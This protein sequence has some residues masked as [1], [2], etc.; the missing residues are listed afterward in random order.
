MS[1]NFFAGMMRGLGAAVG[2]TAVVALLIWILA[3]AVNLPWVGGYFKDAQGEVL[4]LIEEARLTDNFNRIES[5]LWQIEKN[6]AETAMAVHRLQ[7]QVLLPNEPR[8]RLYHQS[9]ELLCRR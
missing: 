6:T 8:T 4:N 7:A 3:K 1:V 9:F 2:A 5:L